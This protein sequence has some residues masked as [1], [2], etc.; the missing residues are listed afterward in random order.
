MSGD[1][2]SVA[3]G[4]PREF[5]GALAKMFACIGADTLMQEAACFSCAMLASSAQRNYPRPTLASLT[6]LRPLELKIP[7]CGSNIFGERLR[8]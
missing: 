5:C 7:S 4:M 3:I 1:F 2:D 6:K 8:R